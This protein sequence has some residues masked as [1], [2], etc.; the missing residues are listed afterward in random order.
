M[1]IPKWRGGG[2]AWYG[3]R[4]VADPSSSLPAWMLA[5]VSRSATVRTETLDSMY[6]GSA[7]LPTFIKCDVEHHELRVFAA[8]CL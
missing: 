7:R 5:R 2:E 4:I 8:R 1:E 3:A 6:V